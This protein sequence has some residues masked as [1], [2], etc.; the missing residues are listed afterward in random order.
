MHV[1]YEIELK[2]KFLAKDSKLDTK[3]LV[4]DIH[5]F[6]ELIKNISCNPARS[7]KYINYWDEAIDEPYGGYDDD[8]QC[9]VVEGDEDDFYPLDV[10]M[11]KK[12][13]KKNSKPK[14]KGTT[15]TTTTGSNTAVLLQ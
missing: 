9:Y 3:Q 11:S 12:N 6:T 14:K 8:Y 5:H 4:E 2:L 13:R 10:K 7:E 1:K 15:N